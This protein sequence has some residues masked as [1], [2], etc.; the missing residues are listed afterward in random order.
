MWAGCAL[1]RVCQVGRC[2]VPRDRALFG[3]AGGIGGSVASDAE[4]LQEDIVRGL[5]FRM[6]LEDRALKVLHNVD[7]A[8][9]LALL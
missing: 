4:E 5:V 1:Y 9:G 6:V 2:R 7:F 3:R 8:V